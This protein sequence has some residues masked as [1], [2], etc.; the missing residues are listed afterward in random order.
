M[1]LEI[2]RFTLFNLNLRYSTYDISTCDSHSH[3]MLLYPFYVILPVLGHGG[4][5]V[6]GPT[7]PYICYYMYMT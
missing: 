2:Q 4:V 3:Y 7:P 1:C 6:Y 5:L